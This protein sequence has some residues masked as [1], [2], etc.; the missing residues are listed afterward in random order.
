MQKYPIS[1][2]RKMTEIN[3]IF[4]IAKSSGNAKICG[5]T[6]YHDGRP[7]PSLSDNSP[8]I[9]L[10]KA[11]KLAGYFQSKGVTLNYATKEIL[12]ERELYLHFF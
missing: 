2:T 9:F 8:E 3:Y 10:H 5:S 7:H 1:F 12:K 6:V 11:S 4:K